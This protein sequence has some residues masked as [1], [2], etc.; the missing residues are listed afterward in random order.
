[1]QVGDLVRWEKIGGG[2]ELGIVTEMD[3][4]SKWKTPRVMVYF[5]ADAGESL[6]TKALLEVIS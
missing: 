1:M 2:Y 3:V 5:F 4:T 6:M